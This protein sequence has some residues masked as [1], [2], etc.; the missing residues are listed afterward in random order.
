MSVS[1]SLQSNG[2]PDFE[3]FVLQSE[4]PDLGYPVAETRFRVQRLADLT[5]ILG[6]SAVNDAK[7]QSE[8]E[9]DE[10]DLD[11][12][13]SKFGVT[14]DE[15]LRPVSLI[16]WDYKKRN[17]NYLNH[18][19]FELPL[20]LDG[21]KPF[22]KF[23]DLET[24]EWLNRTIARFAPFV[25]QGRIVK[26]IVRR[27]LDDGTKSPSGKR[28]LCE[29]YYALP[30]E[31]WR[32]DANIALFEA[33]VTSKWDHAMERREGEL[34]GYSDWQNEWHIASLVSK[35]GLGRIEDT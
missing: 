6:E 1:S 3:W 25:D 8:Y 26:R 14:F 13:N 11:A 24:S 9:L 7:L 10:E 18:S 21:R 28:T 5:E 35:R 16:P 2:E 17:E 29:L 22:A 32:I 27:S 31:E 12:L 23:A 4:D 30:N 19:R 34:L 15:K 33:A 20:M